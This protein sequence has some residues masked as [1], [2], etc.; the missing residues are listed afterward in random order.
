MYKEDVDMDKDIGALC[1]RI[2]REME[3]YLDED[4]RDCLLIQ[5]SCR[6]ISLDQAISYQMLRDSRSGMWH[7]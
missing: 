4:L 1:D 2:R 3:N 5:E 7:V 6:G